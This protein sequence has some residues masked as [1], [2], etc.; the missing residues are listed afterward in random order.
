MELLAERGVG[1]CEACV[2]VLLF[3]LTVALVVD[4]LFDLALA[5]AL[6]IFNRYENQQIRKHKL[7]QE[8][9]YIV[10]VRRARDMCMPEATPGNNKQ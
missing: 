8:P 10:I 5:E 9:G 3:G 6:T 2:P 7:F 1:G 4:L